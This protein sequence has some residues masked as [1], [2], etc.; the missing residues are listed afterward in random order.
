MTETT[1]DLS[2]YSYEIEQMGYI[3]EDYLLETVFAIMA[4]YMPNTTKE[5]LR[6]A[7]MNAHYTE[8][9]GGSLTEADK[10][11]LSWKKQKEEE[12]ATSA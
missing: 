10:A 6:R 12:D 8:G 3:D 1:L 7:F 9:V 2:E 11:Y 5:D 4:D